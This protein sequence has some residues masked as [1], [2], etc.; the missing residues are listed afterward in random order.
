MLTKTIYS[1]ERMRLKF[2]FAGLCKK[3]KLLHGQQLMTEITHRYSPLPKSAN[4][5]RI[6]ANADVYDFEL[7]N[8]DM[9]ALDKLDKGDR[10]AISWNPVNAD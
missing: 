2:L 3:G 9:T 4:E 10:G 1:T 8:D 5:D 6:Q 7:S